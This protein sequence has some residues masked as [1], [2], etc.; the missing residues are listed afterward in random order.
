MA[1]SAGKSLAALPAEK[2]VLA[3]LHAALDAGA[4]LID[5]ADTYGLA[6]GDM[7]HNERLVGKA[8]RGRRVMVATKGG[9]LHGDGS[10]RAN[11][12]AAAI[13]EACEASLRR[14]GLE[15]IPLYQLHG[16]DRAVPLEETAGV[17]ADLRR[18]GKILHVGL[19]NVH[20]PDVEA[21]RAVVPVVSVQNRCSVLD[22]SSLQL[23]IVAFC[24]AEGIAFIA[25]APVGGRRRMSEVAVHPV[26][27]EI[28]S[29]HGATPFQVALAWLLA[30]SPAIVPIPG[31]RRVESVTS[32]AAAANL[33]L[34]ADDLAALNRAFPTGSIAPE[35][36]AATAADRPQK[37]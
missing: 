5:T 7:G 24:E 12:S 31:G 13:R 10:R 11:G 19:S 9:V 29:R 23:G 3:V 26:L 21:V 25:C 30:Q 33:Q 2:E 32:S 27:G 20:V 16:I 17:L 28:G 4:E 1:L 15:A 36:P 14:L 6:C 34:G 37:P 35:W 8:L 22:R 18:E